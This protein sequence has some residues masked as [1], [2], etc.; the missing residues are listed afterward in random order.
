VSGDV[1]YRQG[2]VVLWLFVGVWASASMRTLALPSRSGTAFA[3][4]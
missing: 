4:S 3:G 1:L 2:G